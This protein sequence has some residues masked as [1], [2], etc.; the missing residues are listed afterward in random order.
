MPRGAEICRVDEAGSAAKAAGESC[1]AIEK[2]L[3]CKD[4]GLELVARLCLEDHGFLLRLE[5]HCCVESGRRSSLLE[6]H[7]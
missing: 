5:A 2:T 6:A 1:H 4:L 7:S 3:Q